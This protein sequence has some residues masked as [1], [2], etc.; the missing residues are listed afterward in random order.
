MTYALLQDEDVVIASD[1]RWLDDITAR[2]YEVVCEIGRGG[3]SH[4]LLA[5]D[6]IAGRKVAL[7]VLE[8]TAAAS[9]EGR[10]R[11]RREAL[12]TADADHP[13][14]VPCYEF[15]CRGPRAVAVMRYV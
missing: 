6:R 8:S 12:I 13:H 9:V 1:R 11:F 10:E 15:L 5:W 4:V 3:M 2:R 7:K 14:I